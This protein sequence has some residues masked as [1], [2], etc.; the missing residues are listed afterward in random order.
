[1]LRHVFDSHPI[2]GLEWN[3]RIG[4]GPWQN[5][6]YSG[7][8]FDSSTGLYDLRA[9]YY[10][11]ATGRFLTMDPG[12]EGCCALRPPQ[13]GNLFD[14]GTLHKYL[15]VKGN[16]VNASDPSG[17][18]APE[19]EFQLEVEIELRSPLSLEMR[20]TA[21]TIRVELCAAALIADW[22]LMGFEGPDFIDQAWET[23]EEL[24]LQP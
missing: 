8:R 23:C 9:R 5:F 18:S 14:P 7:E 6:R 15:Y 16:P 12:K 24:M 13:V 4:D 20:A 19:Y 17:R 21:Y 10:N 3:F 2:A 11:P 22:A 1:L